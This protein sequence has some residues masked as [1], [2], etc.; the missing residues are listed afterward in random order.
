M[1]SA[2]NGDTYSGRYGNNFN[3]MYEQQ[4]DWNDSLDGV[5]DG[6]RKAFVQMFWMAMFLAVGAGLIFFSYRRGDQMTVE[7]VE[8]ARDKIGE[9]INKRGP[10]INESNGSYQSL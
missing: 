10:R 5:A 2:D 6:Y 1:E 8:R 3:Q 7:Y 9:I 4:E